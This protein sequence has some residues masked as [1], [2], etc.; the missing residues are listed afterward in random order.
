MAPKYHL[1]RSLILHLLPLIYPIFNCVDSDPCSEYGSKILLN[2]N[3]ILIRIHNTKNRPLDEE[4][5]YNCNNI[6]TGCLKRLF[7]KVTIHP[8]IVPKWDT[9]W[10]RIRMKDA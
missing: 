2:T 8:I 1:S 5:H 7:K 6:G 4:S 9:S 10:I 3:P